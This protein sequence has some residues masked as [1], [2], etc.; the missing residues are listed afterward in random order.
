MDLLKEALA[1]AR[2][3]T[4]DDIE[5]DP[6]INLKIQALIP[7]QYIPDI[8]LRLSYYK[9]LS[10]IENENDLEQIEAEL[11]DQFGNPPEPVLNLMG[12]MLIRH[13]CKRLKIKDISSGVKSISLQFTDKTPLK[14]ETIITLA[15]REN[16]KYS[17]TPDNRLN[18]RLSNQSWNLVY[19][20]LTYLINQI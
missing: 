14:T 20:E 17:I 15:S 19:E 5:L 12:I 8:R 4:P 7:D 9:A 3:E 16:K 2:G 13:L 18:I 6:E 11:R 10:D 1:T